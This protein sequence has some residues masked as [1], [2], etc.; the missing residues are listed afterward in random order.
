M[1][2]YFKEKEASGIKKGDI[3]AYGLYFGA[4]PILCTGNFRLADGRLFLTA[5]GFIFNTKE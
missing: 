1:A 3:E 2:L 5:D 4:L